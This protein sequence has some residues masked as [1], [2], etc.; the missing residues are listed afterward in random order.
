MYKGLSETQSSLYDTN[1]T[2]KTT[3]TWTQLTFIEC[4]LG[5]GHCSKCLTCVNSFYSHNSSL[6]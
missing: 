6:K 2:I 4:L 1:T 3:I 5:H